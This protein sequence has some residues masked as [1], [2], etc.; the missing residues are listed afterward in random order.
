MPQAHSAVEPSPHPQAS[1]PEELEIW[2]HFFQQVVERSR[3]EQ[4]AR[5][6][7]LRGQPREAFLL[8]ASD[9]WQAE[10]LPHWEAARPQPRTRML[11]WEGVPPTV[12]TQLWRL[13]I[14]EQAGYSYEAARAEARPV[15]RAAAADRVRREISIPMRGGAAPAPGVPADFNLFT[16][17][18]SPMHGALLA[19][20]AAL[21]AAAR[22]GGPRMGEHASLL[23]AALLLYLEP[24][25]AFGCM[26]ATLCSSRRLVRRDPVHVPV[27]LFLCPHTASGCSEPPLCTLHPNPNPSRCTLLDSHFVGKLRDRAG[28]GSSHALWRMRAARA[29]LRRELPELMAHLTQL[30]VELEDF[31]PAWLS[32]LFLSTLALDTAAR[33]WDCYLRDGEPLVWQVVHLPTAH[34]PTTP[35][36]TPLHAH[37]T[38]TTT[39]VRA[40][41]PLPTPHRRLRSSCSASC[42]PPCSSRPPPPPRW[43]S[44]TAPPT[45][46]APPRRPSSARWPSAT[47][48]CTSC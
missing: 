43:L 35:P 16:A 46:A 18:D 3:L 6:V 36:P 7:A 22:G 38:T 12:R 26:C 5:R 48:R 31:L 44:C 20:L 4:H 45:P 32:S 29:A 17:E 25:A 15:D 21:E 34:P 19:L 13:A 24:P 23:A 41:S 27:S 33:V 10:I 40:V 37:C 11:W 47:G 14:G 1:T 30:G 9:V 2:T 28:A 39:P 42:L 8:S